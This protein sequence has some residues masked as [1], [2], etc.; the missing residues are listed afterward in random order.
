MWYIKHQNDCKLVRF[1]NISITQM[2]HWLNF[3]VQFTC[4][5]ISICKLLLG[6][7]HV[8]FSRAIRQNE[9]NGHKRGRKNLILNT[10]VC[11]LI[12]LTLICIQFFIIMK[13]SKVF[14]YTRRSLYSYG[15]IGFKKNAMQK[16]LVISVGSVVFKLNVFV[17]S[18]SFSFLFCLISEK[19]KKTWQNC[20]SL[21]I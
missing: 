12:L 9:I 18:K 4:P 11:N 14:V 8:P 17:S 21:R 15:H 16:L 2:F 3:A 13:V 20:I 10:Q 6:S 5:P 7:R 19:R 1:P